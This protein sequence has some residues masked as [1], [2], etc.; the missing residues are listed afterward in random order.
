MSQIEPQK[1]YEGK[2]KEM[3]LI[4]GRAY[5]VEQKIYLTIY[6]NLENKETLASTEEAFLEY[7]T[8]IN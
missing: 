8:L 1:I 7:F 2:G 6:Q 5:Y 4:M 3:V